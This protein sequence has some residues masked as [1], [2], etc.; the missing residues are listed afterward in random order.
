VP[1]CAREPFPK[2]SITLIAPDGKKARLEFLGNGQQFVA[3]GDHPDTGEPYRWTN[4]DPL[5][6]P[7]DEL[8][9]MN[10]LMARQL[11]E[12]ARERLLSLGYQEDRS[13]T[14]VNAPGVGSI[15]RL[16]RPLPALV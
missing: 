14:P 10:K 6:V 9:P 3:F 15:R 16:P 8:P 5:T 11:L 2:I 13:Q 1:F 12:T 4:G 7:A